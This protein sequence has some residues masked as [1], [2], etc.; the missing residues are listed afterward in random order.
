MKADLIALLRSMRAA[1]RD[2]FGALDPA[3]R[4]APLRAGEWSPKDHQSHLTA[5][6]ARHARRFAAARE[7]VELP[8]VEEGDETDE[9]NAELQAER[10]D[11]TWEAIAAEADEVSDRLESEIAATDDELIAASHRLVGGTFGNGPFHAMTHFGWLVDA[12]VGV[13]ADRV[14]RYVDDVVVQ[15]RS[16]QLPPSAV[17]NA[18]YNAA[19]YRALHGEPN[20]A[21][22]LLRES[23][24]MD[25]ELLE[26]SKQDEDLVTLRDELDDLAAPPR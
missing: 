25:P 2:V 14:G 7:G 3:V 12:G 22:E 5:W 20:A 24:Q 19:C 21:R 26:W 16:S 8:S 10:A 1:E 9:L 6:K 15:F 13:D 23:F 4:D 18:I 11:W 17:A